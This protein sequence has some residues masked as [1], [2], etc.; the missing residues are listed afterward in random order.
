MDNL[1]QLTLENKLFTDHYITSWD[2]V[3][4]LTMNANLNFAPKKNLQKIL[5]SL[6]Q[7]GGVI[8]IE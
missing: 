4:Y 1:S 7:E 2:G 8:Q 5:L 6:I 3:H